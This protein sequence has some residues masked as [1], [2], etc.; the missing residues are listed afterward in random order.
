MMLMFLSSQKPLI[1]LSDLKVLILLLF[2]L[3][4]FLS[5]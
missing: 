1:L 5:P 3:A 2:Q 4:S